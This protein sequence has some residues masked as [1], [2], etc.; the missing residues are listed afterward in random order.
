M[1]LGSDPPL[2]GFDVI[3]EDEIARLNVLQQEKE[4]NKYSIT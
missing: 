3:K 1:T 2:R 4:S